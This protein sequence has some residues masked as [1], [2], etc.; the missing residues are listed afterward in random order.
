MKQSNK[1]SLKMEQEAPITAAGIKQA[2]RNLETKC[3]ADLER[4]AKDNCTYLSTKDR[5]N[6]GK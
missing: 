5:A 6:L 1:T 3:D 4:A 2:E